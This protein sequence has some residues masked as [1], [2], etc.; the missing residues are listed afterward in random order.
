M[1]ALSSQLKKGTVPAGNIAFIGKNHSFER[2][3]PLFQ[4]PAGR[5]GVTLLELVVVVLLL[6]IVSTIAVPRLTSTLSSTAASTAAQRISRDIYLVRSW[7]RITSQSQS[8]TFDTVGN[9]YTLSGVPNGNSAASANT[10]AL[11]DGT[12]NA[13]LSSA[14][15]GAGSTRLTFNGFGVPVGLPTAGGTVV[16]SAGTASNTITVDPISGFVTIQ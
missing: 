8:I 9:T 3:S 16:V 15:F 2:D 13:T 14:S 4:Q 10:V 12:L 7:A 6:A 5:T 11:A 1:T